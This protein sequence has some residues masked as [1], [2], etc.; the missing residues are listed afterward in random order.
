M[1]T[2]GIDGDADPGILHVLQQICYVTFKKGYFSFGAMA[3]FHS[4]KWLC[5]SM[6]FYV[7]D[8]HKITPIPNS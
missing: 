2:G 6:A 5:T 4:P 3:V 7:C 8:V 1:N